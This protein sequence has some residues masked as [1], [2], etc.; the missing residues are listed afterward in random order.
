MSGLWTSTVVDSGFDAVQIPPTMASWP[1]VLFLL[2]AVTAAYWAL[3]Q[4]PERRRQS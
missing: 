2:I 4:H 3:N 1:F